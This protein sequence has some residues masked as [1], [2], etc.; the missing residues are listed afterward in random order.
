MDRSSC[1][2]VG[3]IVAAMTLAVTGCTGGGSGSSALVTAAPT[4]AAPTTA[5]PTTVAA[6]TTEPTTT[7][8]PTTAVPTTAVPTTEPAIDLADSYVRGVAPSNCA[9]DNIFRLEELVFMGSDDLAL[10]DATQRWEL[11]RESL[12]EAYLEWGEALNESV[13]RFRAV[14]WPDA[15]QADIDLIVEQFLVDAAFAPTIAN[16]ED[17][18]SYYEANWPPFDPAPSDR[19]RAALGLPS[20]EEDTTYYCSSALS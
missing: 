20:S 13:E 18:L 19:I 3:L 15:L 4:T 14:D 5:A 6:T 2:G 12:R 8:V 17:Y 1:A 9:Y 7:A 16:A 11:N 10:E